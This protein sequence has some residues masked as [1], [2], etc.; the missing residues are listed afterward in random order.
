MQ[1]VHNWSAVKWEGNEKKASGPIKCKVRKVT[2]CAVRMIGTNPTYKQLIHAQM[3]V[4]TKHCRVLESMLHVAFTCAAH[5]CAI[6]HCC[7]NNAGKLQFSA[8]IY[9]DWGRLAPLWNQ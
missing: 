2:K 8:K 3:R 5:T 1:K 7:A 9:L 4:H 6:P